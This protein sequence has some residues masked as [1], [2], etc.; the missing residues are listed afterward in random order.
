MKK[1][2]S[3]IMISLRSP[4]T[5]FWVII[6]AFFFVNTFHESYPDEFDNILGGWYIIHGRLPYVGFFTHHGPIAYFI[7]AVALLFSGQSFVRFRIVYAIILFVYTFFIARFLRKSIGKEIMHPIL[8][9]VGLI[10][11][12]A[13]YYWFHMLLADTVSA[14]L[15]LPTIVLLLLKPLYKKTFTLKD[16]AFIS[17]TTALA[18]L[19]SLTYVYLI[20]CV[21]IF[22]LI[23]FLQQ[24][25][26]WF[27]Q[28]IA[29][30]MCIT[31]A[32]YV[33]FGIY[34]LVSRSFSDYF[35]DSI[36]FNQK[37]YIYNYPR[38]AGVTTINPIRF[39]IVIAYD[40][41]TSFFT[42]L[43]Q[44]KDFNFSYPANITFALADAVMTMYLL[45]KRKFLLTLFFI[46]SCIYAN[47]RSNPLNSG[48][49]DYQSAV[50]IFI[51]LFS[52]SYLLVALY[53]E[54]KNNAD[55][56][57]KFLYGMLFV[58]LSIYA[59]FLGIYFFNKFEVRYYPKYMGSAP[60]IY[61]R[62]QVAPII[63]EIMTPQDTVW[64]GPFSF[65]EL[66]YTNIPL[67]T[68]YQILNPGMGESDRISQAQVSEIQTT[69]PKIIWYNKDFFILGRK[70]ADY[71]VA[72]N[73][74][75]LQ[76]YV[77]LYDYR[78]GKTKYVSQLPITQYVDLEKFLY[79]RKENAPE[80]IQR[81]LSHNLV[82]AVST[83]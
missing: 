2:L 23:L 70:P 17:I 16:I 75:L 82:R 8:I 11:V 40:F 20:I 44:I 65:E 54:L 30:A 37:Y 1:K 52:L 26:T 14:F 41:F 68:R 29:K 56:A 13:T 36:I 58:P 24:E 61:D 39:A 22:I 69:K 12:S 18:V 21:Y 15:L 72:F 42:L 28:R 7:A 78:D 4:L 62:P 9:F 46:A 83:K 71:A 48:E 31:V 38:P 76:D 5:L 32:P 25:K 57:K 19:C 10:A 80:I 53:Q 77:S 45:S 33:V 73:A 35:Y 43:V 74:E 67:A 51:S 81:L 60:L 55:A 27:N 6:A 49:T 47:G 3:A 34:L 79:M 66:F 50:Y 59:L 63:N 64:I